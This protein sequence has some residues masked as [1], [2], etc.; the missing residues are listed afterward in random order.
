MD[1]PGRNMIRVA[2]ILGIV[3]VLLL[4]SAGV[5]VL[6]ADSTTDMPSITPVAHPLANATPAV[7]WSELNSSGPTPP[8][9]SGS[10]IA[11]DPLLD[12]SIVFG[13]Y[14]ASG[15]ASNE[16]W[17]LQGSNWTDLTPTLTV[18]PPARWE[19]ALAYD[20]A[21]GSI[22]L[23]G[24]RNMTQFLND[25][26]TFN[27][28]GWSP[29]RTPTAPSPRTASF[30]YDPS[31]SALF[32]YGG[33]IK[34]LATGQWA[35]YGDTWEFSSG[36]W[37]NL[38]ASLATS[39]PP[40][41]TNLVYDAADGYILHYG[42]VFGPGACNPIAFEWTFENGAWT[43]RTANAATGPGGAYGLFAFGV[44]FDSAANAVVAFGGV[45]GNATGGCSS[46]ADTWE[47]SG[48][49][50][51]N[52]TGNLGPVA[53]GSRQSF[54]MTYD[55]GSGT[56]LLFGGNLLNSDVYY[57]DTWTLTAPAR[58]LPAHYHV[59]LAETGLPSGTSWSASV[60]G[61][62]QSP[63]PA[64]LAF[65]E[66]NGTH[67]FSVPN[68]TASG[69]LYV[70]TPNSGSIGVSGTAVT[71]N[72]SFSVSVMPTPT[73]GVTFA[74]SG[75]P[76][77]TLWSVNLDGVLANSTTATIRFDEPNGSYSILVGAVANY[78]VNY[79]NPVVIQGQPVTVDVRFAN[80][81]YPVLFVET[82]LP[83]GTPWSVTVI[84]LAIGAI[85]S[86]G[87]MGSIVT[88][89]LA[90]GTYRI[91]AT[92]PSG[93]RSSLPASEFSVR[94]TSP[95]SWSVIFSSN[96]PNGL[97]PAWVPWLTAGV[98]VITGLLALLGA[99]WGDTRFQYAHQREEA[100]QWFREFHKGAE[101]GAYD[102][103]GPK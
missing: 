23:F 39:P 44:T 20:P 33:G 80:L 62:P 89:H 61:L 19:P 5:Y 37:V 47:Y 73:F 17:E 77:G 52:V 103:G 55:S 78:S 72:V 15:S 60:D 50:W 1:R 75:L 96:A 69:T 74:E 54:L 51:A 8:A 84:N 81:T 36:G 86:G 70:P 13:G 30:T 18:S 34:N 53:P 25:T 35:Y 48:G 2:W 64:T 22:V 85:T 29:V 32:A 21:L 40:D 92:G 76:S 14:L 9:Q 24:G 94:G 4:S 71:V 101:G 87:S 97:T 59:T 100:Q 95:P 43:N 93:Y 66:E 27:A 57:N 91:T 42:G 67:P 16:T 45:S 3:G 10:V 31:L 6:A 90:D 41:A 102:G 68:I 82:G 12:A 79:S 38:T 28:S 58:P 98:L 63:S 11:F 26:W 99:G 65:P 49:S 56:A 46:S 88:L 83:T 7:G